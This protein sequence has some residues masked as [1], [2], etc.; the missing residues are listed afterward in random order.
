MKCQNDKPR[1]RTI[2]MEVISI[3]KFTKDYGY[4][5]GVFEA[6]FAIQRGEVYGFLGPNGAGKTTT[7]RH[8][9][10][11]SKP[12]NGTTQILGLDSFKHR[13]E[14][15]KSVGYIPGELTLPKGLTGIEFINMM[16]KMRHVQDDSRINE[17]I[18]LFE[19]DPSANMNRMSFG[20]KRK[21]AIIVACMHDPEILILDEPTSGLDPVMQEKFIEFLK[22][23]KARGKTILLSSHIFS[24]V[25]SLCDRVSI[26]KQGYIVDEFPMSKLKH[27]E[28]KT[29]LLSFNDDTKMKLA[30]DKLSDIQQYKLEMVENHQLKI[31]VNDKYINMFLRDIRDLEFVDFEYCRLTLESYF[32]SYYHDD[33]V[34]G[35][36][37]K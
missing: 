9:M 12:D 7:I 29:Y 6:N 1:E 33:I 36:I 15:L 24:E 23:E 28:N 26:I 13:S 16:K 34:F 17:L 5:R 35:G 32:M 27:N 31:M 20:N 4:K 10:G 2:I 14:I 18:Q 37:H 21:L 30:F 8:L 25:E 11:F 3:K 22:K 19:L